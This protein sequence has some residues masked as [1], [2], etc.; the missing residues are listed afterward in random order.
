[1]CV[2]SVVTEVGSWVP[3]DA[4]TPERFKQYQILLE[5][6]QNVDQRLGLPD[7]GTPTKEQQLREL[8]QELGYELIDK[9]VST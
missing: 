5:Q 8:A 3:R 6:M 2:I 7:C 9:R 4:W 1:M